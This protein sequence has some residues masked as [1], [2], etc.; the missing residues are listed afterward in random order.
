MVNKV[1]DNVPLPES[2]FDVAEESDPE[3]A[4]ITMDVSIFLILYLSIV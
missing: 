4:A 3:D 2:A 1:P